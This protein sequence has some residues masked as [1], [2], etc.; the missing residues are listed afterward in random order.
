MADF[1]WTCINAINEIRIR[2]DNA[3]QER[4]HY[5][6]IHNDDQLW[7]EQRRREE[8]PKWYLEHV[9]TYYLFYFTGQELIIATVII[10]NRINHFCNSLLLKSSDDFDERLYNSNSAWKHQCYESKIYHL[11]RALE[12]TSISLASDD[13]VT[14]PM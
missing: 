2:C 13:N 8:F 11:M 9:A 14:L 5:R 7:M 12:W 4:L 10:S 3:I 1:I 6:S